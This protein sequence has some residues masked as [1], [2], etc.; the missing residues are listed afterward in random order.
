MDEAYGRAAEYR[1]VFKIAESLREEFGVGI[2]AHPGGDNVEAGQINRA[3]RVI[4]KCVLRGIA[5]P[6]EELPCLLTSVLR[7]IAER[8]LEAACV[9]APQAALMLEQGAG[10]PWYAYLSLAPPSVIL[11]LLEG[12]EQEILNQDPGDY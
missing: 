10:D 9:S 5:L 12:S 3:F 7:V 4:S 8:A 1:T 6:E 11:D 2:E